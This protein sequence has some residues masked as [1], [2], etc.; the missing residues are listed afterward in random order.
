MQLKSQLKGADYW[1]KHEFNLRMERPER[2]ET[3][4]LS[5]FPG[6]EFAQVNN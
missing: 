4:G 3:G 5:T 1:K 2:R 6:R